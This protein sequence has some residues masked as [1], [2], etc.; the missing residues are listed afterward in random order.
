M[1]APGGAAPGAGERERVY[2]ASKTKWA[3]MWRLLRENGAPIISTWIDE[4]EPGQTVSQAELWVRVHR[5]I[6]ACDR[7]VAFASPRDAAMTGALVEIGIALALGK[8]VVLVGNHRQWDKRCGFPAHPSV[9]RVHDF[10]K[11]F[12]GQARRPRRSG[13][14]LPL[15]PEAP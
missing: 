11:A 4:A 3:A 9:R 7:L 1:S 10:T 14:A 15:T 13:T 8:P 2:V 5:E 6:E 12:G